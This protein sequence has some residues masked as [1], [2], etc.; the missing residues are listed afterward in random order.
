[1]RGPREGPSGPGLQVGETGVAGHRVPLVH[2]RDGDAG[3]CVVVVRG[4]DRVELVAVV[5]EEDEQGT[6]LV[7]PRT[8]G[9]K[10]ALHD[11]GRE[12]FAVC[13]SVVEAGGIVGEVRLHRVNGRPREPRPPRG[14]RGRGAA[15][16]ARGRRWW[17]GG[18][19][20]RP[21]RRG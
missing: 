20:A 13:W 17:R 4:H 12:P 7:A 18:G 1:M 10:P 21:S 16:A 8:G 19:G 11:Q 9:E 2:S 14:A 15:R 3:S 5:D 6:G